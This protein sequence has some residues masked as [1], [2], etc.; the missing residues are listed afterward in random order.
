MRLERYVIQNVKTKPLV[1]CPGNKTR[2]TKK[3]TSMK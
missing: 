1:K 3:L 2:K